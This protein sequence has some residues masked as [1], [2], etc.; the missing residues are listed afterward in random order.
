M[1]KNLLILVPLVCLLLV[2][3]CKK[4]GSSTPQGLIGTWIFLGANTQTQTSASEG[5]GI[6]LSATTHFV[7]TNNTGTITFNKDSMVVSGLGYAV[8][9]SY[10]AYFFF[11]GTVYDSVKQSL[12]YSIP[13]TSANAKYSIVNSDSL[14]FPNGGILTALDST[15]TG[16]GGQYVLKGDSLALTTYGIDSTGGAHTTIQSVL[17]LKRQ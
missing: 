7:T 10:T 12:N 14:Y 11:N 9:T 17:S 16:Q 1:R 6:T 13:P 15:S 2:Y 4:S 3:A 5:S 8:D